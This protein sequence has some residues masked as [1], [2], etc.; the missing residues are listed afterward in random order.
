VTTTLKFKTLTP[1]WTGGASGKPDR[2]HETG[3][4][5]SLRFWYEVIA[6]SLA[7]RVCDPVPGGGCQFDTRAYERARRTGLPDGQALAQGLRRVMWV[8]RSH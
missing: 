5:G 4:V 6:R 8:H 1:I 7:G 3:L 2:L